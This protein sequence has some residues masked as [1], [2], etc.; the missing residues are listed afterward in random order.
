MNI[1][2]IHPDRRI[3]S[4]RMR[5]FAV[6]LSSGVLALG[7][8]VYSG[9]QVLLLPAAPVVIVADKLAEQR[10]RAGRRRL[11]VVPESE[12]NLH[13]LWERVGSAPATYIPKG[14]GRNSPRGEGAGTSFVDQRDGKRLFV[15][16][17]VW[18]K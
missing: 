10:Q 5:V 13:G 8:I 6:L 17:R 14:Y 11:P 16:N 7:T 1:P 15:P 12:W 4:T 9:C 3:R 18:E 2:P